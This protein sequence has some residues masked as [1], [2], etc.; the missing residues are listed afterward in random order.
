MC[1]P[2]RN[3]KI[4]GG[5]HGVEED[6]EKLEDCAQDGEDVKDGMHP[7]FPAADAVEHCTDGIGD[8]APKQQLEA[9]LGEDM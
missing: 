9:G 2:V 3:D 6:G 5:L 7:L 4:I 1:A 8:A